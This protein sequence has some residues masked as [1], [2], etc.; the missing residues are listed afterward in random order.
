MSLDIVTV[1]SDG[2]TLPGDRLLLRFR[3]LDSDGMRAPD[4]L[5]P[6]QVL[7]FE[8]S[9]QRKGYGWAEPVAQGV[10]EV[11]FPV[12][13]AGDCYVF[14]SY[15]MSGIGYAQLPHLILCSSEDGTTVFSKAP[16]AAPAD[17]QC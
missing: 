6:L 4:A 3:L 2:R 12:P 8:P 9:G 13:G 14:F 11:V 1:E 16:E 10:Y 7:L 5:G 17:C 15:P